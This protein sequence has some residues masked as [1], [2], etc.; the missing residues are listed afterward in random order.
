MIGVRDAMLPWPYEESNEW[1]SPATI[2]GA[3]FTRD[4][5]NHPVYVGAANAR[6]QA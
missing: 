6:F 4:F 2:R 3:C 1:Y 5:L